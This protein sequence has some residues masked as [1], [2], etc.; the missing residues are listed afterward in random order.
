LGKRVNLWDRFV[1]DF[2]LG[3]SDGLNSTI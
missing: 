3:Y 1:Y 2:Q